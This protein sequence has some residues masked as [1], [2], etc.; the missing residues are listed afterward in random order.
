MK[1]TLIFLIIAMT[2]FFIVIANAQL[3]KRDKQDMAVYNFCAELYHQDQA[4][5]FEG[6]MK[7]CLSGLTI[8]K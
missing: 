6:Y 4:V 7:N 5:N 3:A 2:L 8:E 1:N